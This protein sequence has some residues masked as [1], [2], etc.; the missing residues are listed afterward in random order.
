MKIF[1]PKIVSLPPNGLFNGRF[2]RGVFFNRHGVKP[3]L[4]AVTT[5]VKRLLDARPD[6]CLIL[7]EGLRTYKCPENVYLDKIIQEEKLEAIDPIVKPYTTEIARSIKLKTSVA[8]LSVL[9]SDVECIH[10]VDL[11]STDDRRLEQWFNLRIKQ[12]AEIFDINPGEIRREYNDLVKLQN[13]SR[14]RFLNKI[15]MLSDAL[16]KLINESNVQSK[17]SLVS[18]LNSYKQKNIL[19]VAGIAHE[20]V[21][22]N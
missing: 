21:F 4:A 15:K 16:Q 10:G 2:P 3:N 14:Q 22:V 8:A 18:I 19:A 9:V 20:P 6:Q 17:T 12:L 1:V 13:K 7:P 5:E 11:N